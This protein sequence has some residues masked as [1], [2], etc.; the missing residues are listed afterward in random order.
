MTLPSARRPT[1]HRLAYPLL[2]LALAACDD[3]TRSDEAVVLGLAAPLDEA[4]GASTRLGAELAVR[5]INADGGIEGRPLELQLQNDSA[6][7]QRAIRVARALADDPAVVGVVGHVNSG[8]MTAA[9][10]IYD[11]N[12]LA[13][14]ATSATSPLVAG[15][16]PWVFRIAS[17]DSAN[18]VALAQRAQQLGQRIA[19][20]Y[21]NDDY[22]RGLAT[23][24]RDA[25]TAAG[26]RVVESD[27]YLETTED[28]S[29]YLER[30]RRQAV[31]LVFI[32]GLEEGAARAIRQAQAIGL[33]ARFI[34]GDG[35][36]G[37][38]GMGP[39]YD[40][41]RVGLLFHP[42]ANPA[43]RDFA[44]AYRAAYGRDP[45]SFAASGY[46]AVRLIARAVREGAADRASI[47]EH[48]EEVGRAGGSGPFEGATGTLRF[49]ER[50][51]PADKEF[52]I[53]VIRDGRIELDGGT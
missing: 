28:F 16:G 2:L 44:A 26:G 22:G 9:G 1:R 24:F 17:S 47:R 33:D 42:D 36:E 20:L 23:S 35:V 5:Q 46:D 40:G 6:N 50:G 45:D 25:V 29:P 12:E 27:P 30:M 49:D 52:A 34:G 14:V 39:A 3:A 10:P 13:A 41:T 21:A 32:A 37:L 8:T 31:D 19:V 15:L 38:V 53:G 4:Y 18:A 48:L 43:A 7:P 11:E 51:D